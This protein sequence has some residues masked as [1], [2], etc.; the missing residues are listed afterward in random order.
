[1]VKQY[2][3][4]EQARK[5]RHYGGLADALLTK[6]AYHCEIAVL[7]REKL[8]S[9]AANIT[10]DTA[11]MVGEQLLCDTIVQSITR[12]SCT[13]LECAIIGEAEEFVDKL[14]GVRRCP[15]ISGRLLG[16][17]SLMVVMASPR[18]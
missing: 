9:Q 12:C 17:S 18:W 6:H 10:H 7:V 4:R 11:M 13:D 5:I 15:T 14:A 8:H 16:A 3:S 2:L 1:M